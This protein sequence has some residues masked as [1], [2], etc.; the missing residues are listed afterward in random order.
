MIPAMIA[1]SEIA[2]V[3]GGQQVLGRRL[4]SIA[5]LNEAVSQGLPKAALRETARRIFPGKHWARAR[6]KSCSPRSSMAFRQRGVW[7]AYRIAD[8]VT[9]SSMG[10][11]PRC[12]A[13][14]GTHPDDA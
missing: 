7:R 1:A 2:E 10:R 8:P 11:A 12:S 6:W 4:A 3:L 13:G 5:A 14:V 9:R